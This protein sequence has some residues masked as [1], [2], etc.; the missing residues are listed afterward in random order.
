MQVSGIT[1]GLYKTANGGQ[2]RRVQDGC[3]PS[4]TEKEAQKLLG[5]Y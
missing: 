3:K 2:P 5:S 1:V 4:V